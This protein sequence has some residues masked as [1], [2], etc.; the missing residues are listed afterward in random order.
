MHVDL[1]VDLPLR[2]W[3]EKFARISYVSHRCYISTHL[4][5]LHLIP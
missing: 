5:L 1:S 2:L 3:N 4:I